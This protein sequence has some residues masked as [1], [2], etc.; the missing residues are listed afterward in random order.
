MRFCCACHSVLSKNAKGPD[1]RSC[2]ERVR[3]K[4]LYQTQVKLGTYVGEQVAKQ[5]EV[6]HER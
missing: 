6:R 3:N 1:C 5:L 4:I 2:R